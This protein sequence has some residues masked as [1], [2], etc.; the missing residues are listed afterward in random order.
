MSTF[1]FVI[2]CCV[3]FTLIVSIAPVSIV[4]LAALFDIVAAVPLTVKL[5][6]TFTSAPV[7]IPASLFFSAVV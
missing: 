5:S 1:L 7:S 4:T 3:P 2:V 6:I